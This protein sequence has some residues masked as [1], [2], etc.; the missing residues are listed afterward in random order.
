MGVA[1]LSLVMVQRFPLICFEGHAIPC[2]FGSGGG[3]VD[4]DFPPCHAVPSI[5]LASNRG[6]SRPSSILAA[7]SAEASSSPARRRIRLAI[8]WARAPAGG[9]FE[10]GH[11]GGT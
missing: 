4:N 6:R 7:A 11:C 2:S 1:W 8:C 5:V 10:S 9:G 3:A